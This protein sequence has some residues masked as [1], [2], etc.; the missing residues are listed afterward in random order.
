MIDQIV[1][2]TTNKGKLKEFQSMLHESV[3]N[4]LSLNDFDNI[5][6]IE[7]TGITFE[8]NALIKAKA[9]AAITNKVTIADDSGLEV[10][11]LDN[12]PGVYSARFAGEYATDDN[13]ID[14]LLSELNT[15]E[16]R[17]ARFVCC[18]AIVFPDGKEQVFMGTCEGEILHER[19]GEGGFGYD[20]VFYFPPEGKTFAELSL[21]E[22]NRYSHRAS[23][24]QKLSGYLANLKN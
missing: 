18:I 13:N 12:R 11:A 14:K 8:E 1:I 15:K 2:A 9:V 4:M 20:P 16:N 24:L 3:E 5:P 10:T 6:E 17:Q 23:A 21:Q 19:K 7:E 22:K